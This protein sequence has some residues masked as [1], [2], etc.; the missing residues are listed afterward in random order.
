MK[1]E[2]SCLFDKNVMKPYL[3]T[4]IANWVHRIFLPFLR[5][6]L[7]VNNKTTRFFSPK[8]EEKIFQ[9]IPHKKKVCLSV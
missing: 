5:P 3:G 9:C 7:M 8:K 6:G 2:Y 4:T 1:K